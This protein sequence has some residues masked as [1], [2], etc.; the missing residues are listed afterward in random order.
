[1]RI[2]IFLLL[3]CSLQGFSQWK[4]YKLTEKGDTLNRIDR[5]DKKQGEWVVH[6]DNVRGERGYE[7]EGVF[8]DD[9]KEGEWRL[10][11]LM[12]DLIGIEH[13]RWGFKDGLSQ[14][15]TTDGNLRLEQN[16]K[17]LNPDKPYDTLMVED[18]DKLNVY[19]EVVVK[20]EGASLKHGEW[21]YYDA[22]TGM[23]MKTENY[24]LG[25]LQSDRS[26]A[27]AAE[28]EKKVVEKPRE[29]QEFEKKNAGKKKIR[30]QDGSAY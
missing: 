9:R 21:K 28:P 20:N 2:L 7:E 23:V 5:Q 16:W 6:Y 25:K 12:G 3:L 17:A 29:V 26:A 18:V 30:Y 27:I 13:Y 8:V 24:V 14:Y 22:V 15:F 4:N 19:R 1:M 11:S 10:F